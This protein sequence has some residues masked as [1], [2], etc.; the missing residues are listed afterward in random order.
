[1]PKI[2]GISKKKKGIAWKLN[3]LFYSNIWR[4]LTTVFHVISARRQ[5]FNFEAFRCDT[6]K[7]AVLKKGS[8]FF[9]SKT[10]YW[11][12]VSKLCHC[13]FP[14][15]NITT[16]TIHSTIWPLAASYFHCL[17]VLYLLHEVNMNIHFVWIYTLVWIYILF[18]YTS[19][20][21]TCFMKWIWIYMNIHFDFFRLDYVQNL[22]KRRIW[23]CG[24]AY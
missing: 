22:N 18:E 24:S 13:L 20:I 16:I 11:Y 2:V 4:N 17:I 7:R 23:R 21:Y 19:W 10:S 15:N 5:L 9:Q 3:A 14:N 6:Y 12:G 8:H 1:M